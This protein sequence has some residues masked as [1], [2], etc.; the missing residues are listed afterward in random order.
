MRVNLLKDLPTCIVSGYSDGREFEID[1]S[2]PWLPRQCT[3]CKVFG[4]ATSECMHK[5]S[6]SGRKVQRRSSSR[7]GRSSRRSRQARKDDNSRMGRSRPPP[8]AAIRTSTVIASMDGK[9][10]ESKGEEVSC[11]VS[12]AIISEHGT[13]SG[14]VQHVHD[15]VALD[16][17]VIS[18]F[19][20]ASDIGKHVL[21]VVSDCSVVSS[22]GVVDDSGHHE[23]LAPA[24]ATPEIECSKADEEPDLPFFLVS[25]RKSGRKVTN[26]H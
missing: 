18:D 11:S 6:T 22:Q 2:Y 4:H 14:I 13:V 20:T 23:P 26:Q 16:L 21:G 3:E 19:G 12:D 25:N 1:V 24:E 9:S 10:A 7:R 8:T 15:G 17:S 5:A